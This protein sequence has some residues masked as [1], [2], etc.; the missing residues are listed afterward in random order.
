MYIYLVT[1][2]ITGK[3]YVGQTIRTVEERWKDHCRVKD[4]NYFH[5]AIR[6]YGKENF[7]IEII[8]TA[9]NANELDQKEIYWIEHLRTLVPHGYNTKPGGNV[10]MRGRLGGYNPKSK[11]IY[12]FRLNGGMVGGYWGVSE[13]ERTTGISSTMILRCLHSERTL[14]AGG[15]IW[16]YAKDFTPERVAKKV[17]TYKRNRYEAVLCVETGEKFDSMTEAAKKHGTYPCSISACCSGKLKTT[18]GYH[19]QKITGGGTST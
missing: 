18:A 15:Y 4:D 9:N 6:K 13:A 14:L 1:N 10:A 3:Q 5:R 16:M 11:L 19:W 12:Q 7:E 2:K 17:D 8:D